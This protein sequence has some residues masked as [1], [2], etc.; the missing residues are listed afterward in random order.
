M[1]K[2]FLSHSSEDKEFVRAVAR[3]LGR[4]FCIF[5]EQTFDAAETFQKSIESHLDESSIF[6]LFATTE[7]IKRIWVDFEVNE[8]WYRQLEGKISKS[9]V[10]IIESSLQPRDLPNWLKRAKVVRANTPK[11]V[12][13]EIR[14]HIDE[15]IRSEQHPYFEGRTADL[16]RFQSM[17]TPIGKPAPRVA[18]IYGLPNIGRKTFIEKAASLTLAFNR[19]LPLLISDGDELVDLAI[20]IANMLEPFSTQA[21]FDHIIKTIRSESEEKLISRITSNFKIAIENKELPLLVDDGGIFTSDGFF[22]EIVKCTINAVEKNDNIYIFI[23]SNRKPANEILSQSLKPLLPDHVKRLISK[24]SFDSGV[25]LTAPQIHELSEYVSGYPPSAYYAVDLAR[26]Y[27]IDAL[28]AEKNKL[29]KFRSDLFI[30]FLTEHILSEE[31]KAILGFLARYSPIPI[32]IMIDLLAINAESASQNLMGLIDHS[33]VLPNETGL[34][35]IAE[36][37]ADA[38]ISA[39]RPQEDIDHK[40]VCHSLKTLLDAHD[41]ELPRL[42]LTRLLFKASMRSGSNTDE[43]FHMTSDLIR[44]AEDFYHRRDYRQCIQF[45]RT[46]LSELPGNEKTRDLLIRSL[47]Q[48]EQWEEAFNEIEIQKKYAPLRNIQFLL[49]FLYR[50]KGELNNAITAYLEAEKLGRSDVAVKRELATCY[51]LNDQL[52]KAKE[53]ISKAMGIKENRFLVDLFIQIAT[54]EGDEDQARTGLAKLESLDTIAYVKHRLSTIELRFGT[55]H[56]ALDAA[57]EAVALMK[58][59]RP[60]FGILSQLATCLTRNGEFSEAEIVIHRLATQ[61]DNKKNDI[62]LG[63]ECRL[64]IERGRYSKALILIDNMKNRNPIVYKVMEK[65]ALAGELAVSVLNDNLRISYSKRLEL[66]NSELENKDVTGSWLTLV[67]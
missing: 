10:F 26:T 7:A 46:A 40:A 32:S 33:L 59:E 27:G 57:K 18:A 51:Y 13:R 55:V 45:A 35:S 67:S 16:E 4:Q 8:A 64:E 2:A 58:E 34:Y 29:V 44:L 54:R 61:Y 50:K 36:P 12:A 11:L 63:L 31:Q 38:V 47:I 15:M 22:R 37:I 43:V 5:D 56:S 65:D 30:K 6:V 53:Y 9:L 28:L 23:V 62:R 49:G 20:K 66:L 14:Q 39:F 52:D 48:D 1:I 25:K 42:E 3:D 41:E 17:M 19:I 60:P 21:G 24:I